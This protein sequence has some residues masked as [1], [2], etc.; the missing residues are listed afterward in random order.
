M[1]W[2][3]KFTQ[4]PDNSGIRRAGQDNPCQAQLGSALGNAPMRHKD[5]QITQ[6]GNVPSIEQSQKIAQTLTR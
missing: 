3:V 1:V 2:P 4:T 6:Q 5:G